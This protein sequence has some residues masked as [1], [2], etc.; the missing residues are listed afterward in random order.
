MASEIREIVV[1]DPAQHL[2]TI[3]YLQRLHN[4]GAGRLFCLLHPDSDELEHLG[5]ALL[6]ALGKRMALPGVPRNAQRKWQLA[7]AWTIGEGVTDLFV[8]FVDDLAPP[9][10]RHL[11]ELAERGDLNLWLFRRTVVPAS[12]HSVDGRRH[13]TT[14]KMLNQRR[15][16]HITAVDA[17]ALHAHWAEIG[18]SAPAEPA[19][20]PPPFPEPPEEGFVLFLWAAH[21]ELDPHDYQRVA[22]AWRRGREALR[23]W[24]GAAPPIDPSTGRRLRDTL[25]AFADELAPFV[26]E[27]SASCGSVHE[28]VC[29]LRGVQVELF[30]ER[31][32]LLKLD[33][34]RYARHAPL[35]TRDDLDH[36]AADDLR[37][38]VQPARSAACVCRLL[39]HATPAEIAEIRLN[40]LAL[41]GSEVRIAG[42]RTE[43]PNVA[44]GLLR[45]QR[46]VRVLDGVTDA[47]APLLTYDYPGGTRA[48][49]EKAVTG[50]LKDATRDAGVH[51]A[52]HYTTRRRHSN[53][54]WLNG[55]GLSVQWF[56]I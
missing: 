35:A 48:A 15:R 42:V 12:A 19:R 37:G 6:E 55:H 17:E 53:T 40:D 49:T 13:G 31:P 38:F 54:G 21:A 43:V 24:L 46:A 26:R 28:A 32:L 51:L 22:D 7:S 14:T 1:A 2:P 8:A 50:W 41:D 11:F 52:D 33:L 20:R 18:T 4:R 44:R 34:G 3:R 9:F 56:G 29:A 23:A 30:R 39:S 45:A 5:N 47:E 27:L 16:R 25:A 36:G 10:H